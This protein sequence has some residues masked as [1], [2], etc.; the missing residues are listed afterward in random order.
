M[1]T[2]IPLSIL[3]HDLLAIKIEISEADNGIEFES[4]C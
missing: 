3:V 1:G 2:K 4:N